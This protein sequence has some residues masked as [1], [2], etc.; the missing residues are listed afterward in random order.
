MDVTLRF[1]GAGQGVGLRELEKI[2]LASIEPLAYRVKQVFGSIEDVNSPPGGLDKQCRCVIHLRRLSPL[3]IRDHDHNICALVQ[4]ILDRA[5]KALRK[6]RTASHRVP[7][8]RSIKSRIK[9]SVPCQSRRCFMQC[10][11]CQLTLQIVDRQGIEVDYC[12]KCR[13][14]WLDRGE[15][16][17][18][19]DRSNDQVGASSRSYSGDAAAYESDSRD[20]DDDE[21]YPGRHKNRE[22]WFSRLLD[23]D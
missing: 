9:K 16:E 19:I 3:V 6:K 21:R 12:P 13:G 8:H 14:I 23:F 11:A 5:V 1:N 2:I 18:L 4:R 7:P 17:K 20:R 22:S 15:L 10:P